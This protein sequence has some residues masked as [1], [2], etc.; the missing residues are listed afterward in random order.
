MLTG[1]NLKYTKAHNYRTVLET[2]RVHGPLSRADIARRSSLTAQTISNIVKKLNEGG[3]VREGE[4][5]R[6][7]RGAPSTTLE[8]NPHAAYS[9]GLD[10]DRDHLTGILVDLTGSVRQ[11]EHLELSFPVPNDALDLMVEIAHSLVDAEG[12]SLNDVRGIGVGFP[13]PI[14]GSKEDGGV[15]LANP[16]AFPE[17]KNVNV[18]DRLRNRLD[19][20][21]YLENNATAAAVGE[22]WYGDHHISTFFYVLFSVGLGGGIIIDGHPYAG[23]SGNA[24]ELGY[25]PVHDIENGLRDAPQMRVGERPHVGEHFHLPRLYDN[26]R[27]EGHD[28]SSPSDLLSLYAEDNVLLLDWLETAERHLGT[29]LLAIDYLLDPAVIFFGGRLPTRIVKDM[30][31]R[32]DEQ[33]DDRRIRGK[34][35]APTLKP[36]TAG[37]DAAALGVATL[38]IYQ[39]FAPIPRLLMKNQGVQDVPS[40]FDVLSS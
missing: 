37:T 10:L 20:P 26:L 32:L 36:G 19:L 25:L 29:L 13:G 34:T 2:I 39:V 12:L 27:A 24:G 14:E 30:I 5:K 35:A 21:I 6:D 8:I 17:W 11:R 18:V 3:L 1:T 23:H 16:T 9:I 22:R 7:G 15:R 38:P 4:K 31:G 28:I 40:L 33:L